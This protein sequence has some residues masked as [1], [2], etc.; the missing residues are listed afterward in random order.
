MRVLFINEASFIGGAE[1]N[2]LSILRAAPRSSIEPVA[3]LLPWEGPLA[4]EIRWLGIPVGFVRYHKFSL[5]NPYLYVQ[6]LWQI[7]TWIWRTR[8][9]VIHLNHQWL[10]EYAVQAGRITRRPTVC[11]MR[12]WKEDAFLATHSKWL[13]NVNTTIADSEAVRRLLLD[14]SIPSSKVVTIYSGID[15]QCYEMAY[16]TGKLRYSLGI[17]QETPLVGCIAR[18]APEKGLEDLLQAALYV[19]KRIS[20]VLFIFIGSDES[21]NGTYRQ[22][23]EN[24]ATKLGIRNKVVFTG[25]RK[26]IPE[27][28]QELDVVT[29]PSHTESLGLS[30]LEALAASRIVVATSVGGVPEMI[31]DNQNGFLVP[32][33]QP[34]ALA[35]ALIRA[36]ELSPERRTEMSQK[37]RQSSWDFDIQ[38]Q[39]SRLEVLYKQLVD[40]SS[41]GSP[42]RGFLSERRS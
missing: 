1:T 39:V 41:L 20:D 8:A 15:T 9:E 38:T 25:F 37:A 18:L 31:A 19:A 6:T 5:R 2:L 21:H 27:L 13:S 26:D 4:E 10:V 16:S 14:W 36:L 23:L 30:V 12:G 40:S 33:K 11:Y 42:R 7:S 28:L 24:Y 35:Q 22:S 34:R 32:P 3:V 17:T 29:L